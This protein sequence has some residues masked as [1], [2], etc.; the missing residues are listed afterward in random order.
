MIEGAGH[1]LAFPVDEQRYLAEVGSFFEDVL[2]D[3]DT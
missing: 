2:A 3:K 1:G